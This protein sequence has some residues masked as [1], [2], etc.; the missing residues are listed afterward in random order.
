MSFNSDHSVICSYVLKKKVKI[1]KADLGAFLNLR[2]EGARAHSLITTSD[3]EWYEIN[4][5]IRRINFNEHISKVFSLIRNA[6][7]IEH[8]LR[9]SIIPKAADRINITPLLSMVTF[10][11]MTKEPIDEAQLI[12][13]YLYGLSE[14]GHVEHKRKNNIALGHLVSYILEKKYNLVHPDQEF[15]E[16]LYY[17]DGS[18]RAIFNKDEP[19]KTH[20]ISDTKEEHEAAPAPANEPN[21]QDLF[22][23]FDRLK[24]HFDQ[25]FDQI[26]AHMQ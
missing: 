14:I 10:L 15:E 2:T 13:D 3:Y 20:V 19:S 11:I 23:R 22:Q 9:T 12:L 7:I 8:V 21:Y 6:R 16:P 17:N 24:T 26:E 25:R 18:F 5:V 4:T 1:T